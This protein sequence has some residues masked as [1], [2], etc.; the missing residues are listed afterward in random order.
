[1]QQE[2]EEYKLNNDE[3]LMYRG[4]VYVPN[5]NE[6]KNLILREMHNVPYVGHTGY[7]KTV[8]AVRS[9]YYWADMKKEVVDFIARCLEC[10]KVKA[11]HRHSTSL[12]QQLPIPKL[13]WE[14]VTM[15]FITKLSIINNQHDSIMVVV[16]K[17]TKVA[18]FIPVKLN[19]KA[20]NIV[21]V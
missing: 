7:Q 21:D 11:E 13:K 6:L 19:H 17:L 18:H 15:D 14:V 4:R 3:I 5:S 1:L 10:Q 12:L 20:A 16:D 8:A 9:Q 2:I